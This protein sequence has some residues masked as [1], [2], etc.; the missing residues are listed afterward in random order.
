MKQNID[1]SI[2]RFVTHPVYF[3]TYASDGDGLLIWEYMRNEI[4]QITGVAINHHN[5]LNLINRTINTFS[6]PLSPV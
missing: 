1:E 4:E 2:S 5:T 3:A 6:K